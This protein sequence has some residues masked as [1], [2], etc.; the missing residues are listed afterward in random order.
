MNDQPDNL[1]HEA[2][3]DEIIAKFLQAEEREGRQNRERW[4]AQHPEFAGELAEFF[5]DHDKLEGFGKTTS[6]PAPVPP[7][8]QPAPESTND[9]TTP[10]IPFS[11]Q[12]SQPDVG[13]VFAGQ[14]RIF[15]IKEGGMGRVYLT[16]VVPLHR[17][18]I[19]GKVAIKT[20]PD[21]E[22]WRERQT[23]DKQLA[24]R[25]AYE[26]VAARFRQEAETWVKIG[27]RQNVIWA[28]F[29]MDVGGKPYIFMEY[30][31]D[32]DLRSWIAQ[33]RLTI[34]LTVNL[35]IQ[36]CRGMTQAAEACGL[37]HRDI[38]PANVLLTKGYVLRVSDFGLSKAFDALEVAGQNCPGE[39]SI[40]SQA[41]AGTLAYM[42]PEQ[43]LGLSKSDTRS[44]IY[45]FGVMLF[46]MVTGQPLF[47]AL[48]PREHLF[49]RGRPAPVLHVIKPGVPP[50]LSAILAHCLAFEPSARY[51]TFREV[52]T[53]LLAVHGDLPFPLPFP[54]ADGEPPPDWHLQSEESSLLSLGRF[55]QAAQRA[56]EG[57]RQFPRSAG[58]WINRG[59]ALRHL[60]ERTESRLCYERATELEP[61]NAL[62]WANLGWAKMENGDPTAGLQSALS[63]TR[64]DPDLAEG[65]WTLGECARSLGRIPE[66]LQAF[67]RAVQARPHDWRAHHFLGSCLLEADQ[68]AEAVKALR[69][70]VHIH[71]NDAA[72][73]RLLAV[74]FGKLGRHGEGRQAIDRAIGLDP[75]NSDA[76][77]VRA[78]V[79]WHTKGASHAVRS[80]LK[81]SLTLNPANSRALK[82]LQMM[83]IK[84]LE[85][86][87]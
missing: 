73:W 37:V 67:R 30:A 58:H 54:E 81:K 84:N 85:D 18:D 35:A 8:P 66:A 79:L 23:A 71:P 28:F 5:A 49:Q 86:A 59:V 69:E 32:G 41:A 25:A 62:A 34:P 20:I 29:V 83:G 14:Y 78:V 52:E 75:E 10:L 33:D 31:E 80:C 72:S 63:A 27:K 36:F 47:E 56:E 7:A 21:F 87:Q 77:A 22:E 16:D 74:A 53:D 64:L 60:G 43:F 65:W 44:D 17:G 26:N 50:A 9:C 57:A 55:H 82:L 40:F 46:E 12:R 48:S 3:L 4:A 6:Q 76:W 13:G 39:S 70:A 2:R 38:K 45:S 1:S 42:A 61:A 68:S 11:A 51:Q 24:D 15:A 19:A